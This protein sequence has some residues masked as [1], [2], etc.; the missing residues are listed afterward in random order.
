VDKEDDSHNFEE[1]A[2]V[3]DDDDDDE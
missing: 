2:N 1:K 3:D